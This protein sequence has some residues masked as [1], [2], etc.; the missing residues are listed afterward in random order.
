LTQGDVDILNGAT[1][2]FQRQPNVAAVFLNHG[3]ALKPG[4]R[5]VQPNLAATLRAISA[6]GADAFYR[7]P[8]AASV[9]AAAKAHGGILTLE[10]FTAYTVTE[11]APITCL[12]RGYTIV[13]APPPSSGGTP[14][15][16][17]RLCAKC[18]R[19]CKA[20]RSRRSAFI[21]PGPCIS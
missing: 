8:I 15:G 11:S 18:S 1:A 9:V 13:S 19:Y 17:P 3:A 2:E 10:D 20:S 6:G 16:A 12:Y 21:P 4:D 5:L 7:G 14:A